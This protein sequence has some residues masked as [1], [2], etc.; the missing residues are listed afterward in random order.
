MCAM[1]PML[2]VLFSGV[3]LGISKNRATLVISRS[4]DLVISRSGDLAIP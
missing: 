2:R 4:G 1:M 3:C